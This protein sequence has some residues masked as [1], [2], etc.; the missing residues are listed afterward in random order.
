MPGCMRKPE[1]RGQMK[2]Y[3]TCL[4]IAGSDSSG[5]AGV[6]ADLK[7]FAALGVYGA[8]AITAVT[9]QDTVRVR[10]VFPLPPG[11]VAAQAEAVFEDIRPR[12]VKIGMLADEGIARAVARVLRKH[13]P[14]FVALDPV[15]VSTSGERLLDEGA[16]EVIK[17]EIFPL[18]SVIIPNLPEFAALSG[19]DTPS[20]T[21]EAETRGGAYFKKTGIPLLLKGGH[22]ENDPCATDILFSPSGMKT[23]SLPRVRTRNTH[24]T[25]CTLS[26]AV[27]AFLAKGFSLP[28]AVGKAKTYVHEALEAGADAALG[29]G[30]GSLNHFFNPERQQFA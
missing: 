29:A 20:T 11:V 24:G 9:A 13:S 23:F 14:E 7:T 12:A 18:V 6:E 5:G 30:A 25:G 28:E 21:E 2:K 10:S 16:A 1:K 26:S 3:I 15:M 8:A 22:F 27:A 17:S 19:F 4:T